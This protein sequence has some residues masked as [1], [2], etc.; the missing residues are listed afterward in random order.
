M[1]EHAEF[2]R[3]QARLHDLWPAITLRSIGDVERNAVVVHSL[4]LDVPEHMYP[5]FPA[6]EERFLCL[7]FSLLRGPRSKVIYVTSQPVLP[8]LIDYFF[9][10]VPTLDTPDARRRLEL[11]TVVDGRNRPLTEKVL[12]RPRAIERIRNLITRP[13]LALLVP[14]NTS[15]LEVDLAVKLGIPI[16]GAHPSLAWA[17]TKQGS[18]RLFAEEGVPHPVGLD[19][20]AADDL[21]PAI[22]EI[23]ARRPGVR[24]VIVKLDEG[25]SGLGNAIVDVE[26]AETPV[27]LR[28]RV[29]ALE[30]EDHEITP[31]QYLAS[32]DREGGIVEE[33]IQGTS[34][35]SPSVQM[36]LSPHGEAE[37]LSTHDQVL[38]GPHGQTYFGCRFPADE[39]YAGAIAREAVKIGR[40]LTREGALGRVALDFVA[41]EDER[42]SWQPYAVEINLRC[43]GTTHPFFALQSLTDGVYEIDEGRFVVADGTPKF[44]VATD[45]LDNPAYSALTPDDLLDLV[46]ERGLGWDE[47]QQTGVALHMVSALAVAGRIGLTAIADSHAEASRLYGRVKQVLDEACG[48]EPAPEPASA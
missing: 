10:L 25:V 4:S 18:R 46:E 22:E 20:R 12:A 41:V 11:V 21:V 31:E 40:R 5:V 48:V 39:A 37:I 34:F 19:V 24:Q 3:L 13:E 2:D 44:Y 42:G 35:R 43:G 23:R 32:L 29:A 33:R 17:G 15:Q 14:F 1:T 9:S 16:Y 30:L 45:H 28:R 8:R 6:Y 26:G 36:R 27:P 47:E 7:V 38:G